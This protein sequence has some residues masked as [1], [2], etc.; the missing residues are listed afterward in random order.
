MVLF[1]WSKVDQKVDQENRDGVLFA[2]TLSFEKDSVL[3]LVHV[4]TDGVSFGTLSDPWTI[5]NVLC[6]QW[7]VKSN[8]NVDLRRTRFVSEL[9]KFFWSVHMHTKCCLIA[10]SFFGGLKG[11]KCENTQMSDGYPPIHRYMKIIFYSHNTVKMLSWKNMSEKGC[12]L[13]SKPAGPWLS[14]LN[15]TDCT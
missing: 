11:T 14:T 6:S 2:F 10:L 8:R 12:H 4:S 13:C 5:W 1:K 7:T 3:F 9:S 15:Q